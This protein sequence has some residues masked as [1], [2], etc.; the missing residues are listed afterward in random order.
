M[1]SKGTMPVNVVKVIDGDS[2]LLK[3]SGLRG[4]FSK[5]FEARMYGIDAPEYRQEMGPESRNAL[6]RHMKGGQLMA[7][8]TDTDRYGRNITLIYHKKRGRKQSVN[9][10]MVETGWAHWYAQY[11]GKELGFDKAQKH[12][13]A[14]S[15]G[16]W[17]R[18]NVQNPWDYRKQQ[19]SQQGATAAIKWLVIL[20]I[21]G[22]AALAVAKVTGLL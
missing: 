8:I 20:T 21:L 15:L 11:G 2:L 9:L 14:N 16:V 3:R 19:R 4:L 7:E 5:E 12:A 13:K 6:V 22:T 1:P 10:A 18:K 17:K